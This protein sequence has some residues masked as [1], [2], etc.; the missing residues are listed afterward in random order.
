MM[1]RNAPLDEAQPAT[2]VVDDCDRRIGRLERR[3]FVPSERYADRRINRNVVRE[4]YDIHLAPDEEVEERTAPRV[5][6]GICATPASLHQAGQPRGA[7]AGR[8]AG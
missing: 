5:Q 2:V 4:H 7:L 1:A 3:E 8:N 6:A